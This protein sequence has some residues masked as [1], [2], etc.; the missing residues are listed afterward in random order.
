MDELVVIAA[1]ALMFYVVTL[2]WCFAK[3]IMLQRENDE[4]YSE[5]IELFNQLYNSRKLNR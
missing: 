2:I 4:L 3:V 1:V 5:N